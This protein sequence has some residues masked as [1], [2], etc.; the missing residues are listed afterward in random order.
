MRRSIVVLMAAFAACSP[1]KLMATVMLPAGLAPGT[2]YQLIFVTSD[3]TPAISTAISDYNAF[4][5]S[6]AA[7][8]NSLLPPG[9]NWDA[10]ASTATVDASQ[11]APSL[12]LP[13]Y[14]T[15]G[16]EVASA[17]N[18]LYSLTSLFNPI[19]YD[20]FGN[21]V[22]HFIDG[23]TYIQVNPYTG[24]NPDGSRLAGFTLGTG[25]GGVGNAYVGR[26]DVI[27]PQWLS[28]TSSPGSDNPLPLYALS[29]AITVP[30]VPEPATLALMYLALLMIGAWRWRRRGNDSSAAL[31]LRARRRVI[32]LAKSNL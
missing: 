13:I 8:L 2:Q 24:S 19:E 6:E 31:R 27:T 20:Q 10:V 4:V 14:N 11:N 32:V 30:G 18:G 7:P 25:F 28:F 23:G 22:L 17:A 26:V 16:Q 5:R 12:G 3:S 21:L 9:V 1:F 15:A 29:S